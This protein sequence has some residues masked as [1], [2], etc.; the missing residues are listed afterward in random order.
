[1]VLLHLTLGWGGNTIGGNV[2]IIKGN[3]SKTYLRLTASN[4]GNQAPG[5]NVITINGDI[6]LLDTTSALTST[7]SSGQDTIEVHV[8]GNITSNGNFNVANGS[9]AQ[10][11]WYLSGNLNISDGLMTTNSSGGFFL[12][13]SYLLA[14]PHRYFIKQIH[15]GQFQM[16][17]LNSS[18]V[19]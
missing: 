17:N 13:H 10:C 18:Q 14:Q 3:I 7:G 6:N 1:M 16:F 12:I 2:N 19:R 5:A 15:S 9:G 8:N 4:I 11:N